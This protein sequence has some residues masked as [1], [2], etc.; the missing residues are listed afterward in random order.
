MGA[1]GWAMAAVRVW[2]DAVVLLLLGVA[3]GLPTTVLPALQDSAF[4]RPFLVAGVAAGIKGLLNTAL[5]P[6]VGARADRTGARKKLLLVSLAILVLPFAAIEVAV[7]YTGPD[8]ATA[9][10]AFTGVDAL[11]GL[12]SVAMSICFAAVPERLGGSHASLTAAFSLCNFTLSS[13]IGIGA[14]LGALGD[15]NNC[16][17]WGLATVSTS[18]IIA[19][20]LD[21]GNTGSNTQARTPVSSAE[22]G[23]IPGRNAIALL[24]GNVTLALLTVVV[25]LD[26]L[27][28]QM[29]VSLLLLYLESQFHIGRMQ[30][31]CQL[32]CVGLSASLSLLV[33]VPLLQP[34][35]GDLKL[36][37]LGMVANIVS[38][39]L[40]AF[41]WEPWQAFLPPVGCILSF[42]V[43]PTANSL[44]ANAVPRNQGAMAQG[45][46][47]GSRTLA[48]GLSPVVFG[49]LFQIA[50]GSRLP[51]WPFL[52]GAACVAVAL[53]V[54]CR[55]NQ[56]RLAAD[57]GEVSGGRCSALLGT[58]IA[59]VPKSS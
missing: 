25:F 24:K 23:S 2:R 36:M 51:G 21:P 11:L 46:V 22:I 20:L 29:L 59:I 54:S 26:F 43:F 50:G 44:A 52:V 10:W 14:V 34:V 42:A 19:I 38:I 28:E 58:N 7:W 31:G 27:A 8:S 37:Q 49:W 39:G 13:G 35:C 17:R 55:I 5:A 56:P 9:V 53:A 30:L 47:S 32:L 48:E 15:F 41:I 3:V 6:L 45:L 12:S 4:A 40:F 16:G 18:V 1:M 33:V 57:A